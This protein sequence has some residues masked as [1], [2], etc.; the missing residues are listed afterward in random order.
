MV[1]LLVTTSLAG[2]PQ[3]SLRSD[4]AEYL[5][6]ISAYRDGHP[7]DAVASLRGWNPA[8]L[9]RTVR[10]LPTMIAG[11]LVTCR[12]GGGTVPFGSIDAAIL[13]HT[14]AALLDMRARA[15]NDAA[16]H[17]GHARRLLSWAS[18]SFDSRRRFLSGESRACG[19]PD[20]LVERDWLQAT[21]RLALGEWALETATRLSDE[22]VNE[23]P[24]DV[25]ASFVAGT[26]REALAINEAQLHPPPAAWSQ[27]DAEYRRFQA[28]YQRSLRDQ[29]RLR[30]QAIRFYERALAGAPARYD[31]WVRLGWALACVDREADARAALDMAASAATSPR[32][33]YLGTLLLGRVHE[34]AGNLPQAIAWY[35]KASSM[36]P[37]SHVAHLALAHAFG[38]D[39]RL[40]VAR[41]ELE[42]AVDQSHAASDDPWTE[43]PH[44]DWRA[45]QAQ[46]VRMRTAVTWR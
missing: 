42:R 24:D 34:R 33:R 4:V 37:G 12:K 38:A 17:L 2:Q 28:A 9:D 23:F 6:V 32:D 27:T 35:E 36:L 46:L 11:S 30:E 3:S 41:L 29:K 26:V 25:D 45:G 18:R 40:T 10:E 13:A 21:A 1:V 22:L 20:P 43:Y 16:R 14:E 31:I 19:E 7:E 44:G 15:G 39:G 5:D 8:R